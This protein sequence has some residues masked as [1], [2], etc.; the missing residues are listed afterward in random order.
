M[1]QPHERIA[2]EIRAEVAR[3]RATQVQLAQLLDLSQAAVSR[4]LSGD[5]PFTLNELAAIAQF[6][7]VPITK[8][9]V[10]EQVA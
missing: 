2:A 9:I 8:F 7:N 1:P 3:Q 10:S 6:L 4:R 5:T